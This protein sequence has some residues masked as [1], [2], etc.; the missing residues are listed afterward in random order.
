M[1]RKVRQTPPDHTARDPQARDSFSDEFEKAITTEVEVPVSRASGLGEAAVALPNESVFEAGQVLKGR[2]EIV[3][4]AFS[5]GMGYVYKAR[6]RHARS[7]GTSDDIVAVKVMRPSVA[8]AKDARRSL[9]DEAEKV[10]SLSHPAIVEIRDADEHDG[11]FFLVMEW[12]EGESLVELLRRSPG[13]RLERDLAWMIVRS[14]AAGLQHA[15]EHGIVH[16]DINPSN[17]FVTNSMDVKLLD[18][19]V[20]RR[21]HEVEH[22]DDSRL[23]WA[24]QT[25]ASPEVLS[26]LAPVVEDDVFSLACVAYRLLG[27]RHPFGNSTSRLAQQNGYRAEPIPWLDA[28]DRNLLRRSLSFDR[29]NRPQS[30]AEFAGD[31]DIR[32]VD[33]VR[34]ADGAGRKSASPWMAVVAVTPIIILGGGLWLAQQGERVETRAIG[35]ESVVAARVA[36][37]TLES[38]ALPIANAMILIANREIAAGNLVSSGAGNARQWF[39]RALTLNP[40]NQDAIVGLRGI[41]DTY[42]ERAHEALNADSPVAAYEALVIASETDP[43]NPANAVV[44]NLLDAKGNNELSAARLA[45]ASGDYERAEQHLAAASAYLRIP[46]D[47]FD[48]VRRQIETGRGDE[49]LAESL[50]AVEA[51]MA[52]GRLVAPGDNNAHALLLELQPLFG[53]DSRVQALTLR[54]G[55]RLLTRATLAVATQ[56]YDDAGIILDAIDALGVLDEEVNLARASLEEAALLALEPQTEPDAPQST[57]QTSSDG[58]IPDVAKSAVRLRTVQEL[59]IRKYVPPEFPR[60]ARE[61]GLSGVVSVEFDIKTNG[62]TDAIDVVHSEPGAMF[63]TSAKTAVRQWQFSERDEETRARI[64]LRFELD[65]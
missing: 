63:V 52:A 27:G 48:L 19:G 33:A 2:Y 26:G 29:A 57:D 18:F 59:G 65:D 31:G 10:R 17:I 62:S 8:T 42:V 6:D 24:T 45:A 3:E 36:D 39:R 21:V 43:T 22:V 9:K 12:L 53:E 58:G 55:E 41:S 49:I 34:A 25:Y 1:A 44:A 23:S 64:N 5:G 50:A 60:R 7:P 20:A 56:N 37:Q 14:I 54:L 30:V 40:G 13:Q 4:T 61:L 32:V 16:A 46:V 15:H 28:S 38:N 35:P 47:R 51:R 11:Q